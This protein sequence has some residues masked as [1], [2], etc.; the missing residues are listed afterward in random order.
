MA[1]AARSPAEP[2]TACPVCGGA[3]HPIAGKCKHCKTDLV[4]LRRQHQA[5][6]GTPAPP[7]PGRPYSAPPRATT[8]PVNGNHGAAPTPIIIAPPIA[9]PDPHLVSLPPT[10][11]RGAW[12]RTWPIVVAVI[13]AAAIVISVILL[14]TG[15]GRHH[16]SGTQRVVPPP[17][18]DRMNTDPLP[19]P[20]DPWQGA[21]GAAPNS[22][23]GAAPSAPN[24]APAAPA[25]PTPPAASAVPA[26]EKWN[27]VAFEAMCQRFS[28]CG[29]TDPQLRNVCN[30]LSAAVTFSDDETLQRI[31]R[32]ECTYDRT[33]AASC[34]A[35]IERFP[36]PQQG[37]AD[38]AA[39][40]QSLTGLTD[41]AEA[42]A[43]H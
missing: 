10:S 23:P 2:R 43:C 19:D 39:L 40:S 16:D 5:A 33:K 6:A 28:T 34:L 17:A 32:G 29:H 12:S 4:K 20:T 36:C 7:Q 31:A 18:P 9:T 24:N 37:T 13:A 14:L 38:L 8:A 30:D 26:P 22:A 35:S 1:L 3:I 42:L 25:P 15:D 27:T 41:C 11:R 21:P